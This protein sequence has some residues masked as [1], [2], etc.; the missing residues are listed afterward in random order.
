MTDYIGLQLKL[1]FAIWTNA[2]EP[3]KEV[4]KEAWEDGYAHGHQAGYDKKQ[5][6]VSDDKRGEGQT[7]RPGKE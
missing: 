6:E 4:L 3:I 2:S 5:E 7:A 1:W